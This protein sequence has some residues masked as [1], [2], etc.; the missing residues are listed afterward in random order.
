MAY[1]GRAITADNR[2]AFAVVAHLH[3]SLYLVADGSSSQPLSGELANALLAKRVLN[4]SQL[5]P[6]D[7]SAEQMANALLQIIATNHHELRNAYPLAACSY[8]VLCVLSNAAFSIHEGD[9]CLGL[10]EQTDSFNWLSNVHSAA[11]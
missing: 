2:D 3:G 8:L 5:L 4:F 1:P 9:C 7:M 10:I 6:P 11:N